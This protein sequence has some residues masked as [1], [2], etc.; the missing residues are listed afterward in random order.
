MTL[1]EWKEEIG[2]RVWSGFSHQWDNGFNGFGFLQWLSMV[3]PRTASTLGVLPM[4]FNC[5]WHCRV[6]WNTSINFQSLCYTMIE[7]H[8]SFHV[9]ALGLSLLWWMLWQSLVLSVGILDMKLSYLERQLEIENNVSRFVGVGQTLLP[10]YREASRS[11]DGTP[12]R[13]YIHR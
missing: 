3:E 11:L 8:I 6:I 12:W 7:Y 5:V 10:C 4:H 13:Y 9:S 2:Q 1:Y